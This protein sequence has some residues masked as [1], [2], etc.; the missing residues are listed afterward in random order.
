MPNGSFKCWHVAL[1]CDDPNHTGS[2]EHCWV[3]PD[4]TK[5]AWIRDCRADGWIFHEG[6]RVGGRVTCP[7]CAK[8]NAERAAEDRP[9]D[10]T[11]Q[12][13]GR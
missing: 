12:P 11:Q 6:G 5:E 3:E 7:E 10:T 2:N 4:A 13:G 9:N 1:T 8:R